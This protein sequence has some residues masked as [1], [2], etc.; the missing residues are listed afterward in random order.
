MTNGRKGPTSVALVDEILQN[1]HDREALITRLENLHSKEVHGR[2]SRVQR[3]LYGIHNASL[4]VVESISAWNISRQ[5]E[6]YHRKNI[7]EVHVASSLPVESPVESPIGNSDDDAAGYPT[8]N[9]VP[10]VP[11]NTFLWNGQN[12]L[13]KMLSDLDFVGDITEAISFLGSGTQFHRNPF[14]L[15]V[16]VDQLGWMLTT[17]TKIGS[18]WKD[19]N[20]QRI[21]QASFVVL[22]DEYHRIRGDSTS[23]LLQHDASYHV[24][25]YPPRLLS[26]KDLESYTTMIDPPATA[27]VAIC[28]AHLILGSVDTDITNKL[29]YLTKAIVLKVVR[30]PLAELLLKAQSYNPLQYQRPDSNNTSMIQLVYPFIMHDKMNPELMTGISI[31]VVHLC[32]WLRT[33]VTRLV[34]NEDTISSKALR[35]ADRIISELEVNSQ[36]GRDPRVH[37][38]TPPIIDAKGELLNGNGANKENIEN[39]ENDCK[40]VSIQTEEMSSPGSSNNKQNMDSPPNQ[41]MLLKSILGDNTGS[42]DVNN[43]VPYPIRITA[44]LKEGS[45]LVSVNGDSSEA[46]KLEAGDTVRI[47]DAH[48]SSNW[49]VIDPPNVG[50]KNDNSGGSVIM[51]HL[52][53]VYDHSR[54]IAQAKKVQIDTINRLCYPYRKDEEDPPTVAHEE[55]TRHVACDANA[56]IHSPLSIRG[57]RV[58][59]LIPEVEDTRT[60]WRRDFD[61]GLIPWEND[62]EATYLRSVKYF[63]VRMSLRNIEQ[64]CTDSPY[65]LDQ[66]VHQQRVNYFESVP[67]TVVIDEAFHTVC[68]WHPKGNLVD[69]VKWAKLSRKMRFLSNVKNANHEID[70]AFVRRS[71][72]RK[73]DL[74]RFHAIFDDIA[75]I[76]YPA[77]SKEDALSKVVWASIVML[78]DVNTMMWKEAKQMAIKVEVKRVC[79]QTRIAALVRRIIHREAYLK[80]KD[81][82]VT[83]AT[84]VRQFLARMFVSNL[85]KIMRD[86][87]E[88][89]CRLKCAVVVQTTWRR[90]FWRNRFIIHQ[91]RRAEEIRQKITAIRAKFQ[92][93]RER[94]KALVVHRDVIRVE[95]VIA[96][97]TISFHDDSFFQDGNSMLIRV[98]VPTTKEIFTFNVEE[99]AIRECLEKALSSEGRLSW[100]EMLKENVLRELT[101]RLILRVVRGRPIFIFSKRNI[102]EKGQLVDKRIV[103]A[104]KEVFILSTFRSPHDFVFN[105]YQP[106]TRMQM[107][108]K[109]SMPKVRQWLS[110]TDSEN[111]SLLHPKYKA[112]LIEWLVKRVVIRKDPVRGCI[113]IL[114]EFEAEQERVL[115]LVTKVQAQWRRL[116]ALRGA[117]VKTTQ[118]YEKIFV[119]ENNI[120]AYRNIVT[121]E[122]Q[123]KKPK[124]LGDED[125]SNPVDEWRRE[126]SVDSSTGQIHHYYANYATGQSS[127]LTEEDAARMVQRRYRSKHES[128]LLGEKLHLRDVVKAMK[129]IH[130][131]R[132]KYEQEPNKLSNIVNM[133]LLLHCLDLDLSEARPIYEKAI[134]QSPN[135]PLISRAYGIFLLASR[136]TPNVTNFQTACRMFH[137]AN[138][139][140]PTQVRFQS[141]AEI[142]FR[143]AVL[144][145]AKNPL[146]LLN[147]AL[148]HQCIYNKY[149]HAEKIYRA[150]LAIDPMNSLVLENYKFFLDERYPGGTYASK[151]PPFSAV[152]RSKTIEERAEWAEWSK[153]EDTE[154]QKSGFS[155]FW[156]NRFTKETLFEQPSQ[157]MIWNMRMKRSKCV[158]G[159]ASNFVEYFDTRLQLPFYFNVYTKQY[160]CVK[161]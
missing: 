105:T 125:L 92:A 111:T 138:V 158:A 23:C 38:L 122:R 37:S 97:V 108:I 75:I 52:G 121:D 104:V 41:R 117:K 70:M 147:Y 144:V 27:A 42:N 78:D 119:R 31:N 134:Q 140:D 51:F 71:Q 123:W 77:L 95:S 148:L 29:I 101:N 44:N 127:W 6:W 32:I 161:R 24:K 112:E 80:V 131:A 120:F 152:R 57:A 65:P 49:I 129:F 102:V 68:R 9:N 89:Q 98:Y 72:D 81:A 137:E 22:L 85:L 114:L 90:F 36:R 66:C 28:C 153:K 143:W 126:A 113:Q 33:L 141:A 53:K 2:A 124:L 59:K 91:E 115:K 139:V 58:W 160:S 154:C 130:G 16:G 21:R 1:I 142:Y 99:N 84:H 106:S 15:S 61:D 93:L 62:D 55:R 17:A 19:V 8:T 25:F 40:N 116:K 87:K 133:G 88:Y 30:Q 94:E 107:R 151:G 43:F 149:D 100:D 45:Q 156:Y 135:H 4:A 83:I 39:K 54:I 7:E 18:V 60:S 146:A 3:L 132:A 145:N 86:D 150:A 63:R 118:Q 74:A 14:L 11:F 34:N 26:S 82:A 56:S 79:A 136:Q 76:Q 67:L 47:F 5:E 50:K 103:R 13:H 69:N 109:L 159:K 48:E 35:S 110:E 73:L 128:D 10:G 46:S 20:A 96:T 155:L 64:S 12:Y 157:D